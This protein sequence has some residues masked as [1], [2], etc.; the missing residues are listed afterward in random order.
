VKS[1]NMI[2]IMPESYNE[3]HV[4]EDHVMSVEEEA[5]ADEEIYAIEE[6]YID[7]NLVSYESE[8]VVDD[9]AV[10][11]SAPASSKVP[12]ISNT[13]KK[14]SSDGQQSNSNL[15]SSTYVPSRSKRLPASRSSRTTD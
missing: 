1:E 3:A 10:Y 5:V 4:L 13:A 14:R 7:E 15:F 12:F 11:S 8:G 2:S 6:E 9:G